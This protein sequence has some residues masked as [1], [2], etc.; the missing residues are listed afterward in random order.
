MI[1]FSG[2]CAVSRPGLFWSF[3]RGMD[4]MGYIVEVKCESSLEQPSDC[5]SGDAGAE[6]YYYG[7]NFRQTIDFYY[8][9]V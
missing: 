1:G 2:E 5:P 9:H 7:I 3:C 4:G 8:N 6:K